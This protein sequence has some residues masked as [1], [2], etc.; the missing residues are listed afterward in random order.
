MPEIKPADPAVFRD[1]LADPGRLAMGNRLLAER[2]ELLKNELSVAE[3]LRTATAEAANNITA[4]VAGL[5]DA[6][7]AYERLQSARP[8]GP[9]EPSWN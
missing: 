9:P 1:A 2:L 6:A 8:A 7:D 4:L 5:T 3:A